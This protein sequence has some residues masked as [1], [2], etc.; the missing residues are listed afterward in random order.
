MN[1]Q[2]PG[3]ICSIPDGFALSTEAGSKLTVLLINQGKY[4]MP[5]SLIKSGFLA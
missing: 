1:L 4:K 2:G 5:E 3:A